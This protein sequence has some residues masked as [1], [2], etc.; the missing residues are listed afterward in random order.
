MI[1]V[2][3]GLKLM[4][5]WRNGLQFGFRPVRPLVFVKRSYQMNLNPDLHQ[6]IAF[7]T[8]QSAPLVTVQTLKLLKTNIITG[9]K[10]AGIFMFVRHHVNLKQ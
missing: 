6:N 7:N 9:A 1:L 8:I 3:L 4:I 2:S 10:S 5:R